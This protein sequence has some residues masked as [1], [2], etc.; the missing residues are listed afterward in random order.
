MPKRTTKN[1]SI[2]VIVLQ[3][4]KHLGEKFEIIRVKP[5]YARNILLPKGIVVLADT[6]NKNKYAQKMVAAT[7]ERANKAKSLDEL[8]M[9][10]QNDGGIVLVRKANKENTLYAK[11]DEND[12][13]KGIHE[14]YG[15]EMEP[16]YIKLKKK[17]TAL[18]QYNVPFLYKELKKDIPVKI[19]NDPEEA[20]K[21][22][23][24]E[25]KTETVAVEGEPEVVK[26]KAELRAEK[27]ATKA[28]E[29]AEKDAK[30]AIEKAEKIKMLKEKYK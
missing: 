4:D 16:H 17:L 2:E 15:V 25:G 30:R 12:I 1:R 28:K 26:T 10:I 22:N 14:K 19:E 20:K 8:F 18:G 13:A 7:A 6:N 21:H 29:R 5:V 24:A 27:E 3:A 9:K 11:V 23:K